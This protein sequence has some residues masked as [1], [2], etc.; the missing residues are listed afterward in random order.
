MRKTGIELLR[1]IAALAVV[2]MH[3]HSMALI[4]VVDPLNI[5]VLNFLKSFASCGVD[6]FIAITGFFLI[7][8]QNRTLGKIISLLFQVTL[9]NTFLYLVS[10]FMGHT[11]FDP[12]QLAINII[13]HNYFVILYVVMYIFSPYVNCLIN[14]M[15]DEG[16]KRFLW[17]SV[18]LFS[19]YPSIVNLSG[20]LFNITWFGLNSIGAWGSQKGF[21]I[22]NFLLLYSIGACLRLE[23]FSIKRR[24]WPLFVYVCILYIW[25]MACYNVVGADISNSAWEYHNPIV[26][27]LAISLLNYFN[28]FNF[29][30]LFVNKAAKAAFMCFLIH[31]YILAHLKISNYVIQTV[32]IMLAHIIVSIVI[33]YLISW[34][35]YFLYNKIFNS[36]FNKLD[37][38][39]I[40]Y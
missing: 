9:V 15:S 13:P 4:A 1:I 7:K 5:Q 11:P 20:E 25:N 34:F 8:S 38:I 10:V 21:T 17:I 3:Y 31:Q 18:C 23:T 29:Q 12:T 40:K 24:F 33:I 6:V 37:S 19:I 30:C 32:W 2:I 26:I 35:V 28:G 14:S 39:A 22:V 27:L 36:L 16:R